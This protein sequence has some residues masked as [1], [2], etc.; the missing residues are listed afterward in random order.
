MD[1]GPQRR[2]GAIGVLGWRRA[3]AGAAEAGAGGETSQDVAGL[4]PNGRGS[5]VAVCAFSPGGLGGDL[6]NHRLRSPVPPAQRRPWGRIRGNT[7][8]FGWAMAT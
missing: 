3:A 8:K 2:A 6:V 1:G 5:S 7:A 4:A